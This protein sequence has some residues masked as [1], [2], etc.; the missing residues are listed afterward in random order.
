MRA[1]LLHR[2]V[3]KISY[4][5][6]KVRDGELPE[7]IRHHQRKRLSQRLLAG[8]TGL[9]VGGPSRTFTPIGEVPAYMYAGRVDNTNFAQVTVWEGTIAEG[10]T[11]RYDDAKPPGR[12]YVH[13]ATDLH[14][15]PTG[16]YDFLLSSHT[17][18]H[19]A[20]PLK[21]LA[22]WRRVLTEDG[23][24]LITLPHPSGTFDHRRPTTPLAHLIA[25]HERQV[26]E[27][28]LTHVDEILEHHDLSRD[29]GAGDFE[30]FRQRSLANLQNRCLHHHVFD[31]G[32]AV[33][34]IDHAGF[35]ILN[36]EAKLPMHIIVI[37]RKVRGN[38]RP[39]NRRWLHPQAKYRRTSPFERDRSPV[40]AQPTVPTA[41]P[42]VAVAPVAG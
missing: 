32:S 3:H 18:E 37:A 20:N 11:F 19:V 25:D 29:P 30:A 16:S 26:G 13:D 21:V 14:S 1:A 40:P 6:R 23:A 39:D 34:L 15:I 2:L 33:A 42:L 35:Q 31:T 27:D 8:K 36:V 17:L 9:E 28:D 7:L 24:I 38:A 4:A 22:E 41:S 12:Q 10:M 5:T